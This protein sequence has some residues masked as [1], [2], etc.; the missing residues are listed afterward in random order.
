MEKCIMNIKKIA[1]LLVFLV[2]FSVP[3]FSVEAY[4]SSLY[5]E[6]D[7]AFANKSENELNTILSKNVDD[8]NYYLLENY[9][10]KKV[11]HLIIQEEYV[12]AMKAN[13]VI[14]D[15]DLDNV[16]AVEMYST[17]ATALEKQKEQQ[18]LV[19][20]RKRIAAAK[21]ETE[22]A[23]QRVSVAKD[24]QF[25]K[26]AEGD[27][28]YLKDK[29]DKYT[30]TYWKVRFGMFNGDLI[31]ESDSSYDSFRYGIS[32]D[33]SYEYTFDKIMVGF[34][35][36]GEAILIPFT[37]NDDTMLGNVYLAPKI[38]FLPLSKKFFGR[39]GVAGVITMNSTEKSVLSDTFVTPL[40]GLGFDHAKAGPLL[41]SGIVDYYLAHLAYDDMNLAMGGE[42]NMSV[43]FTDM[44]KVRLSLNVGVKDTLF[45]KSSGIENRA[46]FILAIGAENVAK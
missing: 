38:G 41:F 13:L 34:D 15:N 1:V 37:N 3:V 39:A 19:E 17:I 12:F 25:V 7:I 11:R 8:V 42:L 21:F 2:S 29:N 18:A 10:M 26:T 9:A 44:E 31:T 45:V 24:F 36:G 4:V 5:R 22:K 46:R 33:F 23:K 16:D 43:P 20:E 27:S 35:A 28:V 14:I 40:F 30:S 32:G 6:I